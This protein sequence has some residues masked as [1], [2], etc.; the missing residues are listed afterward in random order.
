MGKN[1]QAAT[2][3]ET[4]SGLTGRSAGSCSFGAGDRIRAAASV[5]RDMTKECRVAK[6]EGRKLIYRT[7]PS[8][9]REMP[10][11]KSGSSRHQQKCL[12]GEQAA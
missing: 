8:S 10:N 4:V 11:T 1:N 3:A 5:A 9:A 12:L 6:K 2:V 7:C